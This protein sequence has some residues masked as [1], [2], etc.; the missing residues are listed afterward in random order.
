MTELW[1][2]ISGFHGFQVSNLGRVRSFLDDFE[3]I[4]DSSRI[5]DIIFDPET[6]RNEVRLFR[7]GWFRSRHVDTLVA[8]AFCRA[9]G[10]EAVTVWHKDGDLRNDRASNL[11]LEDPVARDPVIAI[12]DGNGERIWFSSRKEAAEKLGLNAGN[13]SSVLSGRLRTAGIWRFE[14]ARMDVSHSGKSLSIVAENIDTGEQIIFS[15]Q[16][17]AAR[18]LGL[19][20]QNISAVLSG[21]LSRTGRYRFSYKREW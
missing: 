10:E 4:T 13:I 7:Y 20:Q 21:K 19:R 3:Q 11:Y 5:L 1:R 17:E 16:N 6:G 14:C 18:E 15:S 9:D 2:D 12:H 8:D